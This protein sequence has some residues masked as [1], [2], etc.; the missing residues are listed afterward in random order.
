MKLN[1]SQK[2]R[3]NVWLITRTVI[4]NRKVY[5]YDSFGNYLCDYDSQTSAEKDNKYSNINRSIKTKNHCK[6][7]FLWGLEKL[8]RYCFNEKDKRKRIGKFDSS[9]N[10]IETYESVKECCQ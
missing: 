3:E 8:D 1:I 7:G 10:L 5:K 6:N 2:E 4:K 9:N